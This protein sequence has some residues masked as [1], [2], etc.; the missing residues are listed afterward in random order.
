MVRLKATG[1]FFSIRR[2]N[3]PVLRNTLI[4]VSAALLTV[5]RAAPQEIGISSGENNTPLLELFTSEGC[6]SCPPAEE[7]LSRQSKS[8]E[9]WKRFVPVAFHV[10]YWNYLGWT[11]P[12]SSPEWSA[13]Q[14]D[15]SRLGQ[16]RSVYTPGFFLNGREWRIGESLSGQPKVGVL[17]LKI[18]EDGTM[19]A[20]FSPVA[21][22]AGPYLLTVAPL[23][24]GVDQRV[25]GGENAGKTL[26]HDFVALT[27]VQAPMKPDSQGSF[28]AIICISPGVAA[29][30]KAVAAWVTHRDEASPIQAAGGWTK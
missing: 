21:R 3:E 9:L 10:D 15:Y 18:R 22:S 11:D 14:H 12:Y 8:P 25:Q 2:G 6:S 17:K 23:A 16:A 5:V 19:G 28:T 13:R 1:P 24:C 26:H 30:M 20:D 4:L 27:I 7:W 29:E